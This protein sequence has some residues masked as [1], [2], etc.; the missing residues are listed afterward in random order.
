M[1]KKFQD[2]FKIYNTVIEKSKF[3][4]TNLILSETATTSQGGCPNLSN[5]FVSGF[6]FIS[7]LGM[8]SEMGFWQVYRQDLV[9]FS[10]I[11]GG[12][13]YALAGAS[14]WVGA[15]IVSGEYHN[16][17]VPLEPNPDFY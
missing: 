14:G 15:P 7:M 13:S 8:T 2:W 1:N 6:Y 17:T 11:G 9:G 12:S 5:T 10:G 3:N 4:D 16:R